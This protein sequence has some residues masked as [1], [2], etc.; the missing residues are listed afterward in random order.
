M[1]LENLIID[2]KQISK[3]LLE[4]LLK[5]RVGLIKEKQGV[6]LTKLGHSYS[7]KIRVLLFLCGKKAW[8]L[9]TSKEIRVSIGEIEKNL[10]IKGNT[11]RPLLK[12]LKDSYRVESEKGKYRIL[13]KGIFELEKEFEEEVKER[14]EETKT[15]IKVQRKKGLK[16]KFSRSEFISKLYRQ[17][18]FKEHKK[19]SEIKNELQRLGVTTKLS[20]LPPY[21]LPLVRKGMLARKK[22]KEGKRKIWVYKSS[23]V[24]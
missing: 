6:S 9:L 17:G 23:Q 5:G 20:S 12:N 18:F 10:G 19:L 2:R 7:S 15:G 4:Q 13:P 3:E 14:K 1:A 8:E 24:K 21:L 11:L 16:K 22:I